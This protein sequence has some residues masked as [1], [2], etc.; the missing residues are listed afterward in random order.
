MKMK[1]NPEIRLNELI[2]CT[3]LFCE[4]AAMLISLTTIP[5]MVDTDSCNRILKLMRYSGYL[6]VCIK[7]ILDSYKERDFFAL[8]GMTGLL[9]VN[10]LFANRVILLT[11]LFI[12]G[13]KHMDLEKI[14][15]YVFQWM[16][17]G[18]VLIILGSQ[19]GII[20]N[21]GY[22]LTTERPRYALGF[23]YPS[24]ATSLI[25]YTALVF[26]TLKKDKLDLRHFII[27]QVI[28]FWQYQQTDSRAGSALLFLIGCAFLFI[29]YVK[30]DF[31]KT[32]YGFLAA[33]AFPVCAAVSVLTTYM[34][35][36][37]GIWMKIN[38]L[39]T[40]RLALGYKAIKKYGI[41]LF[42]KE[43]VWIGNGG[44]GHIYA[45]HQDEYNYVDCSYVKLL[46]ENGIII[47]TLII[48]GY[49]LAV[50]YA[51]KCGKKYLATALA[52]SAVYS[53]IEPRLMELGFN[54][55]V[56]VLVV[57]I[58]RPVIDRAG[59]MKEKEKI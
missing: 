13:M 10:C 12:F 38:T 22:G 36:A 24:H 15:K 14:L 5:Y 17:A 28:N 8:C 47:W 27:L 16:A 23:F 11:F 1:L 53:M 43:I 34:Y 58:E 49:T 41:H 57:L 30:K 2:F 44:V 50:Y 39:L 52:F 42:G 45:T 25:V 37:S 20:D 18:A 6:I 4:V 31:S 21:W 40:N 7:I 29:K 55:F 59:K 3:A 56:L 19:L 54:P 35:S 26:L 48:V 33:I 51:V 32:I 46:L 9:I